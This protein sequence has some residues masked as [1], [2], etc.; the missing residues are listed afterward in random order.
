MKL[1]ETARHRAA[2][3]AQSRR[4]RRAAGA[5]A[6]QRGGIFFRLIALAFVVVLLGVVYLARRPLLRMAG[7]FWIVD[8]APQASDAIV[9]LG[10]DTYLGERA[11]LAA[12][13]YHA[14]WAPRIIASGR[15]LRSYASIAE[16]MEHDLKERGVPAGAIVRFAHRGENTRL[17]ALAIGGL[18][19]ERGWKRVL[20]VTSNYHTRRARYICE[21]GF[22]RSTL[23]RVIAAPDSEYP[24]DSWWESRNGLK[25]FFLESVGFV[26]AMWE[27]RHGGLSG[28][29]SSARLRPLPRRDAKVICHALAARR[30]C[31]RLGMSIYFLGFT[32]CPDCTIVRPPFQAA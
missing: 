24:P 27:M 4:P 5:G 23:L 6:A 18:L 20:V 28:S 8:E 22:P 19:Q 32:A 15:Y 7:G 11:A 3:R 1:P 30:G 26:V 31:C 14:G 21:R 25:H 13:L 9:I 10:D 16:L 17:E 29:T 2:A 12:D